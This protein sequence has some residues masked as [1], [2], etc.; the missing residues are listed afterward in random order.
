VVA[1]LALL[2]LA[3]FQAYAHRYIVGPDGVSY[4]DLSD[5][6]TTGH[7]SRLLNLYWSPLYPA[8]I[9]IGRALTRASPA[10]EIP[11]IHAV[12]FIAFVAMLAAFEYLMSAILARR[13]RG[14]ALAGTWGAVTIYGLFGFFALIFIPLELT[15]PD[16]FNAA[17]AFLAFGALLRL[18]DDPARGVRHA[19]VL[20]AS[21]GVAALSKSFMVPW[22]VVVFATL[23]LA[24]RRR[25]LRFTAIAG[26]VWLVFVLPWSYALSVKAGRPTFGDAGRLTYAWFVNGQDPPAIGGVPPGARTERTERILPGSGISVDT[27]YTDPMWADPARWNAALSPHWSPI[28]QW[29][30]L[31]V[32]HAFYVENLAPLLLLVFLVVVAPRGSRRVA[33]R[34]GW[35]VHVP[36]LLG[37]AAY[38]MVVVTTRYVMPFVLSGV[39]MLLATLPIARRMRPV[40]ALV[41]LAVPVLLE[42][43]MPRTLGGLSFVACIIAAMLAAVLVRAAGPWLW[44]LAAL[45]ALVATRV[46]FP[47]S[48][49]TLLWAAAGGLTLL[50]WRASLASIRGGRPAWFA[51]RAQLAMALGI[52]GVL[53][54]RLAIRFNQD[55]VALD[56]ASSSAWGNAPARIAEDL[57]SRGIVPGTRIA[58]IGP[59]AES[60]W[61]RTARLHIVANVPRNRVSEFWQLS[62]AGQDSLLREFAAAGAEYAIATLGV[63]G[64]TPDSSWD[65]LKFHG[66]FKRLDG[67]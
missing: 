25:G 2:G 4:L 22:A 7:W 57:A 28:D 38:A 19:I 5:A 34:E 15:T 55:R 58:V 62:P 11:V 20:G 65:T 63:P 35:I 27:A 3:A 13:V 24:T 44:G 16:G 49:A 30:T 50:F 47:P 51:R 66:K 67:R 41:G 29:K 59:H 23:L 12:D 6:V 21:L 53:A 54:F 37:L 32:F 45:L 52:A 26:A 64:V 9:G 61:A 43:L 14:S 36:A 42:S 56:Q 39:L 31:V 48:I 17:M 1:W 46:L 10:T 33:W 40:L 18:V 8:L 60:Y